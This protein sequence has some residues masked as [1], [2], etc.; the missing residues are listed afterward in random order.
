LRWREA[1]RAASSLVGRRKGSQAYL[2]GG[3]PNNDT[4]QERLSISE[5][6]HATPNGWQE[7][8]HRLTYWRINHKN[9]HMRG[10]KEEGATT[11]PFDMAVANRHKQG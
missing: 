5:G 1:V 3:R 11:T 4:G 9:L 10:Y 8:I 7:V 2:A 6:V